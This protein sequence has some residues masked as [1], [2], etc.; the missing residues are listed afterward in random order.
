MDDSLLNKEMKRFWSLVKAVK[1]EDPESRLAKYFSSEADASSEHT[2]DTK[3]KLKDISFRNG[4]M[5]VLDYP[6]RDPLHTDDDDDGGKKLHDL[7][8]KSVSIPR[9]R[10]KLSRS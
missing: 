3:W 8:S 7:L 9:I 4:H 5:R 1:N 6:F 2:S 10:R